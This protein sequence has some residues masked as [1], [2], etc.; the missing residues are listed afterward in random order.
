MCGKGMKLVAV[1]DRHG[2]PIGVVTAPANLHE[3]NL[4]VPALASI[5][6]GVFVPWDVPVLADRAYDSDPLRDELAEDGYVLLAPHRRNRTRPPR[7]DGRRMRRY[8]RRYVVER[9]FGWLHSYRRV[10]VRQEWWSHLH[11]GFVHLACALM[12]L[13]QF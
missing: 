13:G 3:A 11:M 4:A 8:R 9:T 10:M 2:T 5:P 6:E 12:A 1:V 7:N